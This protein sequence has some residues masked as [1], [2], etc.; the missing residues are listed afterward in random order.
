MRLGVAAKSWQPQASPGQ[1]GRCSTQAIRREATTDRAWSRCT[2]APPRYLVR[3]VAPWELPCRCGPSRRTVERFASPSSTPSNIRTPPSFE[4]R[5][6]S[7]GPA[8]RSS[9]TVEVSGSAPRPSSFGSTTCS[10]R[11]VPR[12]ASPA[13]RAESGDFSTISAPAVV[14]AHRATVPFLIAAEPRW[15]G[16][17]VVSKPPPIGDVIERRDRQYLAV[18]VSKGHFLGTPLVHLRAIPG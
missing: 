14:R 1:S 10:R 16:P 12:S 15:E 7:V 4:V 8:P 11:C 5:C 2:A 18:N 17:V 6:R 3:R 13:F 9:L